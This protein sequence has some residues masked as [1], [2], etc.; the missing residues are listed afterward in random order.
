MVQ[1]SK[2]HLLSKLPPPSCGDSPPR[3]APCATGKPSPTA[4]STTRRSSRRLPWSSARCSATPRSTGEPTMTARPGRRTVSRKVSHETSASSRRPGKPRPRRPT[5]HAS[6]SR[7]GRSA[8]SASTSA[9]MATERPPRDAA[10]R[11]P[12]RRPAHRLHVHLDLGLDL[13]NG[14]EAMQPFDYFKYRYYEKWLGGIGQFFIDQGYIT[15]EEL[16]AKAADYR[17][18]AATR[19]ARRRRRTH[20]RPG[21]PL[22][23]RG[24]FPRAQGRPSPALRR[25]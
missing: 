3:S 22:P 18:G 12:D 21:R 2:I 11:V 4:S 8:S 16:D 23:A 9:M 14:A 13:R 19:P 1:A 25:R 24:R 7:T 20:R 17:P 15:A 5:N 6:S 10:A